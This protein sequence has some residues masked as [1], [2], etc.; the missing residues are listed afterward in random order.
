MEFV[1]LHKINGEWCGGQP[2]TWEAAR[3]MMDSLKIRYPEDEIKIELKRVHELKQ[4]S[5]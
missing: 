3:S 4:E 5:K 1:V 2:V